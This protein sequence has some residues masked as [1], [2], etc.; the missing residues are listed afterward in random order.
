MNKSIIAAIAFALI[1]PVSFA[2][3]LTS[4]EAKLV[5]TCTDNPS[6]PVKER[7][8]KLETCKLMRAST[9]CSKADI[10]Y[11]MTCFTNINFATLRNEA[12]QELQLI[13]MAEKK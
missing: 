4:E 12:I 9:A 3:T 6:L 13:M 8:S 11:K 2:Q 1:A 10:S 7:L 5:E